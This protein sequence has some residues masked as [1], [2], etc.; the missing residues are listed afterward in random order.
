MTHVMVVGTTEPQDFALTDD[1]EALVGTGLTIGIAFEVASTL[2]A[3]EKPTVAWLDQAA[4][5]VRAT[6]P[7]GMP[8][9][10]H[11]F[12]WTLTDSG[13]KVG[14]VPNLDATPNLWRVVKV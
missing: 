4:G 7:A 10:A 2:T 9:G 12:R 13:G 3:E 5:T 6:P 11:R 1:G 8:V 14:F